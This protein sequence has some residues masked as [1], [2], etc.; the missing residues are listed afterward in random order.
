MLLHC[1]STGTRKPH[2]L[3]SLM[4]SFICQNSPSLKTYVLRTFIKDLLFNQMIVGLLDWVSPKTLQQQGERTCSNENL[5]LSQAIQP[6]H[7]SQAV[8]NGRRTPPAPTGSRWQA[9]SPPCA[10]QWQV[11]GVLAP[12]APHWIKGQTLTCLLI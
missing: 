1:L 2:M 5:Q 8:A 12:F 6:G 11:V 7:L 4:D 3:T 9:V 10:S